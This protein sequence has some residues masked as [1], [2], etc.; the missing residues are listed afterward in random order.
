MTLHRL[1]CVRSLP[2]SVKV[3]YNFDITYNFIKFIQYNN[4]IV[5]SLLTL[6]SKIYHQHIHH[7]QSQPDPFL[8][9]SLRTGI[10]ILNRHITFIKF[11]TV[12][13]CLPTLESKLIKLKTEKHQ[14]YQEF[15]QE[16]F[17]QSKFSH[18]TISVF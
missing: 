17:L 12:K 5:E 3:R 8:R 16:L 9:V 14:N 11:K 15:R 6:S 4:C 10:A 18:K 13:F 7:F 2:F 1:H